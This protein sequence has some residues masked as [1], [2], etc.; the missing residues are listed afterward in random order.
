MGKPETLEEAKQILRDGWEK[1][2]ECPC[3]KQFVKLYKRKLNA[4]MARTMINMYKA[5]NGM[6]EWL[7]H[8]QFRTE[9]NDYSYLQVWELIE[10]KEKDADDTTKKN[11]GYWRLTSKGLEFVQLEWTVRSHIKMYNQKFYG[12]AGKEV[13]IRECLGK[14]FNYE[15]LMNA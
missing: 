13:D 9:S 8:T 14:K 6:M 15:E 1:G 4:G 10:E 7:H 12:F 5:S 2:V 3:C 11:S